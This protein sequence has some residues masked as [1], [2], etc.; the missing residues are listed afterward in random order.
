MLAFHQP[1]EGLLEAIKKRCFESVSLILGSE[2][3][4]TLAAIRHRCRDSLFSVLVYA[5]KSPEIF[6]LFLKTYLNAREILSGDELIQAFKMAARAGDIFHVYKLLEEY[7]IVTNNVASS[8]NFAFA[9]A[10]HFNH[11]GI[12]EK[13]LT[14]PA[15]VKDLISKNNE[16]LNLKLANILEEYD[17]LV[18][19]YEALPHKHT[20]AERILWDKI[21][22]INPCYQD[23]SAMLIFSHS[24][25]HPMEMAPSCSSN[26]LKDDTSEEETYSPNGFDFC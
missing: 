11:L 8:D 10:L 5:S 20:D 13:L 18:T 14:Y 7:E 15:V 4:P 24:N 25:T 21:R 17:A 9:M 19:F 26:T 3:R 6:H 12:A 1:C 2:S 16:K 23:T 22:L